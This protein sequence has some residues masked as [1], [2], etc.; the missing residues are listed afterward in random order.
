MN[1]KIF[2]LLAAGLLIFPIGAS[3]IDLSEPGVQVAQNEVEGR[4]GKR[5]GK[6]D[7]FKKILEQ[8]DLTSEQSTQ[9]QAIHDS[10]KQENETV[11][12]QL[13]T[14]KEALHELFASDA[15]DSE[16]IQ[17]HQE[18]QSLKQAFGTSRFETMLEIRALLTPEQKAQMNEL[19]QERHNQK[20]ERRSQESFS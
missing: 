11:R 13:K 1:S 19:M 18:I 5:G 4:R 15:S 20:Q 14:E 7:G 10:N 6:G 12:E 16:L 8:L 9:I 3:A 2:S 17:Q